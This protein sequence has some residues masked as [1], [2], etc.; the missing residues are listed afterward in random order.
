MKSTEFVD[1]DDDDAAVRVLGLFLKILMW[2]YICVW[3]CV[4]VYAQQT[5]VFGIKI[6]K[7]DLF[8]FIDSTCLGIYIFVVVVHFCCVALN[9]RTREMYNN[10]DN[11]FRNVIFCVQLFFSN[12]RFFFFCFVL[13][14]YFSRG[15]SNGFLYFPFFPVSYFGWFSCWCFDLYIFMV[16]MHLIYDCDGYSSFT[17]TNSFHIHISWLC[18]FSVRVHFFSFFLFSIFRFQW[19]TDFWGSFF[20]FR[21]TIFLAIIMACRLILRNGKNILSFSISL[22]LSEEIW[23]MC[24]IVMVV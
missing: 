9:R 2:I 1:D 23:Q 24:C 6:I 4:Y 21:T 20:G 8:F 11:I 15:L 5:F 18:I 17:G 19:Q 7:I 22:E 3:G 12:D 14:A 13:F 16:K 10:F